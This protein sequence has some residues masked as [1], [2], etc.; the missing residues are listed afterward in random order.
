MSDTKKRFSIDSSDS[1]PWDSLGSPK[2][3]S[4]TSGIPLQSGLYEDMAFPMQNME[5]PTDVVWKRPKEICPFPQ[6]I[7]DGATRMDIC[8][9]VLSDCWFLSAVAS[10]SLYPSLMNRVI[11]SGQ[12]FQKGYNGSFCFR[13]WQYGEWIKIRVDD[14]LPTRNGKL[15]YLRS[16]KQDEF[17][18]ALLEKAYAKMNG[19]YNSLNMGFPH[20]AMAD[21]TGGITEVFMMLSLPKALGS[22]L[23]PLLQK[24]ALINCGNSQGPLEKSNEFGILFRHA[25][26]VTGLETIKTTIGPVMLVRIRN[27]WGNTEWKGAWSDE[28][29]I[30]WRMVS[31]EEQRRVHRVQQNDGEF[32]MALS[33]FRQNFD[34][35]EV[36]H[37]SDDTLNEGGAIKRPWQC[38]AHHGK[39]IPSLGP[40][41]FNLTLLEEDDDP[42]DSEQ[43]C[44]FLLALMQK[45]SRRR[46]L[47]PVA[48]QIFKARSEHDFLSP[49][50]VSQFS[51]VLSSVNDNGYV[52]RRELVMR[53]R[54]APG[55]YII[56]PTTENS[57]PGEF[58][59]RVLTEKGNNSIS[60]PVE[61]PAVHANAPIA[62]LSPRLPGL[63]STSEAKVL[64]VKHSTKGSHCKP[65]DLH[66]LLTEAIAKGVFAGSEQKLSLE[67]CKS[68]VVLMDTQ[69][70]GRLD[71]TEF[72]VLWDKLRRWTSIFMT[73]DKNKN[74]VLEYQEISPALSVAGIQVDEFILQLI[75]LRYTEPDMTVSFPGF[76]FLLM[77]LDS[78]I[79]K[80]QSFDVAGM[81]MISV[82]FRQFLLMTTYN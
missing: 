12:S 28:K 63:P 4:P 31:S 50:D 55:H 76:L 57:Q 17:W 61:R 35:I 2:L 6:F 81:G 43:T 64:F 52:P 58:L 75:G 8:Q 48:L 38:T 36:C 20:E 82:N 78:M 15:I 10:L 5:I 3:W 19:G 33:D 26:S 65:L 11:P 56:I 67:H 42:S 23:H 1:N 37:L 32:W 72:L 7:V 71:L 53:G 41:Q 45:H 14:R 47:L 18:S 79:R 70:M 16:A 30:E 22:F 66:N 34:M 68:F 44:L 74:K 13:F 9:G 51:P 27:P 29:G 24:G 40:P 39:W 69:G 46:G 25:Y 77:K 60:K 62:P 21:M 49:R 80:F 73:F 59:L 54:L